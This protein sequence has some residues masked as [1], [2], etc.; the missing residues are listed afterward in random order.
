MLHSRHV[1]LTG[2]RNDLLHVNL[3]LLLM[4]RVLCE[5][6]LIPAASGKS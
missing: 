5:R 2:E 4:Q 6:D 3:I 1:A